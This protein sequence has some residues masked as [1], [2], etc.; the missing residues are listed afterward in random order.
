MSG[1]RN[2][3]VQLDGGRPIV[4]APKARLGD[5]RNGV[6]TGT[7]EINLDDARS[8][9]SSNGQF[10]P[11]SKRAQRRGGKASS[12]RTALARSLGLH[13]L[14][15]LP[16]FEP[17]AR[18]AR[19]F[20]QA[21][22]TELAKLS[23]GYVTAVVGAMVQS[24]ALQLAGSRFLFAKGDMTGGS[25]LADGARS[26]LAM[27]RH[28]AAQDGLARKAGG[29]ALPALDAAAE[30]ALD[31]EVDALM[32]KHSKSTREGDEPAQHMVTGN[33]EVTESDDATGNNE[34]TR[35]NPKQESDE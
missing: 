4:R 8:E 26:S 15:K 20:A 31:A 28:I 21:T 33:N 19:A 24:A 22:I 35:N 18:E 17:F 32:A 12:A 14:S 1:E 13:D 23:G 34:V 5:D 7:L 11:G 6:A 16:K 9:R 25:R 2:S 30:A 29:H 10:L 3:L 27:A